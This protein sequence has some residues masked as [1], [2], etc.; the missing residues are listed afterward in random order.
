MHFD[1]NKTLALIK[2]GLLDHQNTWKNYLEDCPGWQQTA[3]VLTGPLFLANI[4]FSLILSRIAGG[5][6]MYMYPGNWF[7][8]L[9]FS[10][11]MGAISFMIV[12]LVFNFLAGTFKGTPNFSRAFAAVSLA[13]IPA[14]VAGPIAA[15]IPYIGFLVALAGGILTL[16][17][18]Y[19]IMPQALGVPDDK[20]AVHFWVSFIAVIVINMIIGL[21]LG[22]GRT[23]DQ[24]RSTGYS[25]PGVSE[26]KSASSGVIAEGVRQAEIVDAA[27]ADRYDPPADGKLDEDQVEDYISVMRKT[28][29]LRDEYAEKM[30]KLAKE[31]Q[32]KEDAGESPSISDLGKIY[33]GAGGAVSANNAEMEVVKTGGGNW[34]EHVWVKQ[35]LRAAHV[36]KGEGSDAIVHNYKLY[37]E[38][39]DELEDI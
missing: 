11:V 20:R 15:L 18:L 9:I 17:F 36:Q 31:M 23:A 2:G 33:A 30:D 7:S 24:Y 21:T 6:S 8:A 4:L 35:Q 19:R 1:F 5:Y 39:E 13:I 22:M 27:S 32:A 38:Y 3:L 28:N 26:R 16:V 25:A 12:V 10:L 29:A 14:W 37:K 34:A